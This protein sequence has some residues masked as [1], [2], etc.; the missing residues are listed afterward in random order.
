MTENFLEC[1]KKQVLEYGVF[2]FSY[3]GDTSKIDLANSL[4][5]EGYT[6]RYSREGSWT[7]T[8]DRDHRFSVDDPLTDKKAKDMMIRQGN[9]LVGYI[10]ESSEKHH[11][12][13]A[14]GSVRNQITKEEWQGLTF[15]NQPRYGA[16][17]QAL[18]TIDGLIDSGDLAAA[19]YI[20]EETLKGTD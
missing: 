5:E 8:D 15:P 1:A 6:V 20:I 7:I 2:T 16:M 11:R 10:F 3:E 17:K 13:C 9:K 19:K 14:Y 12:T 4:E 18:K